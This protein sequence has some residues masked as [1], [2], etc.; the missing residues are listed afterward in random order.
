[1][2]FEHPVADINCRPRN[3]DVCV[4]EELSRHVYTL[5]EDPNVQVEIV[6]SKF[7]C[8]CPLR[9]SKCSCIYC[10]KCQ[11]GECRSDCDRKRKE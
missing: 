8:R 10:P 6:Q 11:D 4:K 3:C 2:I 7:V 5:K 9:G 1:M